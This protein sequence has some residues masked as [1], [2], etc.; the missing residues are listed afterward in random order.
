M[1]AVLPVNFARRNLGQIVEEAF[2][3]DKVFA[4]T[5][6]KRPMAMVLSNKLF[7]QMVNA[8][9]QYD[10]AL[11]DTIALMSNPELQAI[12]EEDDQHPETAVSF[13]ESLLATANGLQPGN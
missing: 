10:Y 8:I 2:Y 13:D 4:L 5:R 9:E 1:D 6:S 11:A 7:A 12:L 3:L